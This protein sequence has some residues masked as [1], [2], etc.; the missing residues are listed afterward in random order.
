[1]MTMN[2]ILGGLLCAGL[3]LMARPATGEVTRVEI[4]T[5]GPVGTSGYEKIVGVLHFAVDPKDPRNAVIVDIDKA[6]LNAAGKVEFSAD[7][8]IARPIDP[9]RSNGVAFVDVVNRGRKT[10]LRFARAVTAVD[11]DNESASASPCPAA[12]AGG[13]GRTPP[14]ADAD[15]DFGDGFL[16]KDGYTLVFVGWQFDVRRRGNA[17]GIELPRAKGVSTVV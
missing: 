12:P 2:R 14:A 15:L 8:Y 13:S 1:M 3:A 10:T 11:T 9:A 6:P 16:T 17:M 7:F 4:K 5:R